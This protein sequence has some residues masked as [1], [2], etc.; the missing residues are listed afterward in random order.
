[1]ITT[2]QVTTRK[3]DEC[4]KVVS[5]DGERRFGGS[6]F[7]GWFHVEMING[8]SSVQS[9]HSQ[10]EFD[11]C[12]AKCLVAHGETYLTPTTELLEEHF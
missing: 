10:K 6:V 11:L 9:L 7:S 1:M 12:G 4:G 8:S 5:D 2:K 3:C